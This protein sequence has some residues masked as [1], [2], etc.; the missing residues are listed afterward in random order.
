MTSNK[1]EG[2]VDILPGMYRGIWG[3]YELEILY[4]GARGQHVRAKTVEGVRGMGFRVIVSI[5]PD[6]TGEFY[7]DLSSHG[8]L[9]RDKSEPIT[10]AYIREL[11]AVRRREIGPSVARINAQLIQREKELV[12]RGFISMPVSD[13]IDDGMAQM[14]TDE[15]IKAFTDVGFNASIRVIENVY[16]LHIEMAKS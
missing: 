1:I 2:T 5:L 9:K 12:S 10:P 3:A 16:V 6:K 14:D 8:E 7:E 13:V 4:A 15:I 11:N